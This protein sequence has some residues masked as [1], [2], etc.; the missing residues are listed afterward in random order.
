MKQYIKNLYPWVKEDLSWFIL[1]FIISLPL[2]II[3]GYQTFLIKDLFD[4]GFSQTADATAA[5]KLAAMIVG[6]QILNY[7]FRF[8]H[9]YWIKLISERISNRIRGIIFTK[10]L[11]LP[12]QFHGQ[13]KQGELL[14]TLSNDVGVIADSVRFFPGMV[15]EPVSAICLLGVAFYHDFKLTLIVFIAVPIFVLIFSKTGKLIKNRGLLVQGK[16]ARVTHHLSEGLLGQKTIKANNLL[17]YTSARLT[18]SQNDYMDIYKKCASVEEHSHPLIELVA[19]LAMGAIIIYAHQRITQGEL[20]TGAF[21]SFLAAL[22]MFMDPVRKFTDANIKMGRG[23]ASFARVKDILSGV[24]EDMTPPTTPLHFN[25]SIEFKDVSFSYGNQMVLNHI[26]FTIRKGEKIGLVGLSGSGKSTIVNLLLRFY[27]NYTGSILLDGVDIKN[28]NLVAFRQ[29]FALVSQ[30]VFLFHDAVAENLLTGNKGS[31][32]EIWE[33]LKTAQAQEFVQEL[34][35]KLNTQ[36]GDRGTKLS[37]G[38]AQRLTIA[39]AILKK[40]P[41]L[42]FDEATS[43]LD[44]QSEKLVQ[45]ALDAMSQE[46]TVIAIAHRLSTLQYYD[47]ILVLQNGV[48]IEEGNHQELLSLKG[49]YNKL[50]ELGK[51]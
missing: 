28:L 25:H 8:Y 1:T 31:E 7:P 29:L 34:P 22:A 13:Q 38:Q 42:L 39:R 12:I 4:H 37:G 47:K 21:V 30:D 11:K 14:S 23:I 51:R 6:L 40:S 43:A 49:E 32:Q 17:S 27:P 20:T 26:N 3:K 44:N 46:H 24:E 15:R 41:V 19:S 10:L 48:I 9:F 33:A 2:G 16:L 35:E 5:Y 36:V 45:Q 50:Y 18:K